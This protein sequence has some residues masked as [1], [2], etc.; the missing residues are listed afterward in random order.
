MN[1][2]NNFYTKIN[3]ILKSLTLYTLLFHWEVKL[4][5]SAYLSP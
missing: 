4:G 2:T 1:K 3:E 5:S